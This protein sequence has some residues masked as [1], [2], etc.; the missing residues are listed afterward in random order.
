MKKLKA[1]VIPEY[2]CRKLNECESKSVEYAN[3]SL[4]LNIFIRKL[5]LASIVFF[6]PINA[7]AD[8]TGFQVKSTEKSIFLKWHKTDKIISLY[9]KAYQL[10]IAWEKQ[11]SKKIDKGEKIAELKSGE[12][13][14]I[15]NNVKENTRYY[16][17]LQYANDK[18]TTLSSALVSSLKDTTPPD[19][20]K[21][22]TAKAVNYSKLILN[23]SASKSPD[24]VAYRIYRSQKNTS[25][26]IIKIVNFNNK[27]SKQITTEIL[28]KKNAQIEYNYFI[29]AV[30]G[31]GNVSPLSSSI[32]LQLPDT[33][34]PQSPL[35][36]TATQTEKGLELHWLAD[37]VN[38][39]S[40]YA[41]YRKSSNDETFKKLNNDLIYTPVFIDTEIQANKKY[42]YRV[43]AI[44][45]F[46]NES[47]PTKGLLVFINNKYF[48]VIA[49]DSFLITTTQQGRPAL[50]WA[51]KNNQ[52]I[53]GVIVLR[54]EGD[55]FKVVSKLL[56]N[57]AFVDDSVKLNRS[58]KYKLKTLATNG[59]QSVGSNVVLWKGAMK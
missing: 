48:S 12:S 24:V 21:I 34:A 17:R 46:G 43:V 55:G 51:L 6:L 44:D 53:S 10:P 52:S 16:Y 4:V 13:E 45:Q 15:D 7:F 57:N 35:Q 38:D 31:A 11:K 54:S 28:Q 58:Y 2:I 40:G 19:A 49:P 37:L 3:S 47:K 42:R 18:K 33:I 1:L 41:V 32:A 22:N 39:V 9:R 20:V 29:S 56:K 23:W 27:S 59:E 14:Y 8:I 30:D 36:L 5:I 50:N 25:P 26:K